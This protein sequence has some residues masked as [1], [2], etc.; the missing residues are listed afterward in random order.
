MATLFVLLVSFGDEHVET[1]RR[2]PGRE[3]SNGRFLLRSSEKLASFYKGKTARLLP[4]KLTRSQKGFLSEVVEGAQG[5]TA[6]FP[7]EE[8]RR[9]ASGGLSVAPR[10]R[11]SVRWWKR[12]RRHTLCRGPRCSTCWMDEVDKSFRGLVPHS[13]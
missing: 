9:P 1:Y 7:I 12:R 2:A 11:W 4:C 10:W 13:C 6:S 5:V 8:V 3:G